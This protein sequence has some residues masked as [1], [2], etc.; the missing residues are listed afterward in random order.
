MLL[1]HSVVSSER[2]R[3]HISFNCVININIGYGLKT[4]CFNLVTKLVFV[5]N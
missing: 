1:T 2:N 5:E 4:F 3:T